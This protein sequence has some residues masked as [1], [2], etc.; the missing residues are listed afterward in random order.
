MLD[1]IVKTESR[2]R[3]TIFSLLSWLTIKWR[4]SRQPKKKKKTHEDFFFLWQTSWIALNDAFMI[5][6]HCGRIERRWR[7]RRKKL[8]SN[9]NDLQSMKMITDN[10]EY[11]GPK[12]FYF[13]F[14]FYLWR[15]IIR[16]GAG[17]YGAGQNH[18]LDT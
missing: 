11:I 7:R 14:C 10:F 5:P 16:N 9:F 1:R 12:H 15:Y 17:V 6:W 13:F 2:W 4:T 3:R 18:K 8:Q